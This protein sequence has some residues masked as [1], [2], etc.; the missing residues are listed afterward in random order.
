M[1]GGELTANCLRRD[2]PPWV[3]AILADPAPHDRKSELV[4]RIGFAPVL[5]GGLHDGGKL[6]QLGGVLS[7]LHVIKQG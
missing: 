6:M 1:A 2:Q 3:A 4:G 5:V 7:A